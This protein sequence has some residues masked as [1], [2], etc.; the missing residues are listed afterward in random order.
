MA[1]TKTQRWIIIV[2]LVAT[3]VGTLGSFAAMILASENYK[4]DQAKAQKAQEKYQKLM[5][6]Y[7]AKTAAQ[8]QELSNKYYPTF[9]QY[10]S[11][12]GEFDRDSVKELSSED[13]VVGDGEEIK[14]N[15]AFAAYYIGWNPKGKVFDQSIKDGKLS[16]PFAVEG[17]LKSASVITGWK[18]SRGC[19]LVEYVS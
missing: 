7:Q 12:V 14:D 15:T 18:E 6:D 4:N 1:T 11:R 9:S 13:L 17:G 5:K 16:A 2:I 3:V 10:T 8:A 19:A